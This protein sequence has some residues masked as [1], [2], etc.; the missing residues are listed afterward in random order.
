MAAPPPPAP[1]PVDDHRILVEDSVLPR[2]AGARDGADAPPLTPLPVVFNCLDYILSMSG[3]SPPPPTMGISQL[4][5]GHDIPSVVWDLLRMQRAAKY[6]ADAPPGVLEKVRMAL[7]RVAWAPD[8]PW[9]LFRRDVLDAGLDRLGTNIF[10][11][12]LYW[13]AI[14][15]SR[16]FQHADGCF[17]RDALPPEIGEFW[18]ES[19][20]ARVIRAGVRST[21]LVDMRLFLLVRVADI[22]SGAD[23][24]RGTPTPARAEGAD[25]QIVVHGKLLTE[26]DLWD[27]AVAR[28]GA[29]GVPDLPPQRE[30]LPVGCEAK[31]SWAAA[32]HDTTVGGLVATLLSG[33]N[34]EEIVFFA[35][36]DRSRGVVSTHTHLRE[37]PA[38]G[39]R[40][41]R[42]G[43][44][45]LKRPPPTQAVARAARARVRRTRSD[46]AEPPTKNPAGVKRIRAR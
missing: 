15:H 12:R 39:A 31:A 1:L 40:V 20:V 32:A 46:E 28:G 16:S 2:R 33:E 25:R 18:R 6:G 9:N 24:K 17:R 45:A 42:V 22:T 19:V 3:V 13:S 23:W 14:S 38:W 30:P 10:K 11:A 21:C 8:A 34:G 36:V 27:A 35:V 4:I 43:A 41:F 7:T 37:C 44:T 5:H 26:K 29:D